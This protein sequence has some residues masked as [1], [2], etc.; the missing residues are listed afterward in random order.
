MCSVD[1]YFQLS[2][3]AKLPADSKEFLKNFG[4][5]FQEKSRDEKKAERNDDLTKNEAQN[6]ENVNESSELLRSPKM[7]ENLSTI[8][9]NC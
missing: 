6:P 7:D 3:A 5:R 4:V 1:I 8:G 2:N 9:F